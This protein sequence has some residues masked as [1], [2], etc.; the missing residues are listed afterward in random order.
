MKEFER[1]GPEFWRKRLPNKWSVALLPC[2][3][4]NNLLRILISRSAIK[5][6]RT[7]EKPV[8]DFGAPKS[9]ASAAVDTVH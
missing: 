9:S 2:Q 7:R 4:D 8:W 3:E 1:Q 5:R 6:A